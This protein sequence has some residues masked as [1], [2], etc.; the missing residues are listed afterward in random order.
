MFASGEGVVV[1]ASMGYNGG[2]GNIVEID[3]GGG[4]ISRYAHL[5]AIS[6]GPGKRVAR[7]ETIGLVGQTGIATAPHVHFEVIQNGYRADPMQFLR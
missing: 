4:V 7:G 6:V 2:F 1:L 5:S 3:H